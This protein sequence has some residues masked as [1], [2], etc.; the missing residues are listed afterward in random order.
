MEKAAPSAHTRFAT[1]YPTNAVDSPYPRMPAVR[2]TSLNRIATFR[3]YRSARI[4]TGNW[5]TKTPSQN[6]TSTRANSKSDE[7]FLRIHRVQN[8]IQIAKDDAAVKA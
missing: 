1:T 7:T 4:P 8:G 2:N 5:Y 3:P 6:A